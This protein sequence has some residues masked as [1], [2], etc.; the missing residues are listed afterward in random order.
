MNSSQKLKNFFEGTDRSAVKDAALISAKK[1]FGDDVDMKKVDGMVDKAVDQT[2]STEDAIGMVQAFFQEGL[3]EADLL[4]KTV[5]AIANM[6]NKKGALND[7]V[8][9]STVEK[10]IT[11]TLATIE[12]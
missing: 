6:L 10:I 7:T 8:D 1:A 4:K 2:D 12:Q 5:K 9:M 3:N 11:T